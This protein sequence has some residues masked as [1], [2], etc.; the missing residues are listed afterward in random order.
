MLS[1]RL[2]RHATGCRWRD[3]PERSGPWSTVPPR[4]RRW[5]RQERGDRILAALRRELDAAG[6][7]DWRLWCIDGSHVR[8]HRVTAGRF[9]PRPR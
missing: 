5:T 1:G 3:L 9:S 2:H 4:F 8:A 7:I 6:Q